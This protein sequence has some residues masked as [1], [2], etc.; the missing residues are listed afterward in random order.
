MNPPNKNCCVRLPA[1]LHRLA[2]LQAYKEGST[3]QEWVIRLIQEKLKE[4]K[5]A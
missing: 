4:E 3:L 1:D 5:N 2:K